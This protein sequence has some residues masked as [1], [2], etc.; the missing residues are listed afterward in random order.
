VVE[1][2]EV[3]Q[4]EVEQVEVEQVEVEQV[5][6]EQVEVEQVEVEV[7]GTSEQLQVRITWAGGSQTEGVWVRPSARYSDRSDYARLCARVQDLTHAGWS[8]EAMAHQLEIDG[9][10]TLR[11][12]S[13][14]SWRVA[15]VQTLRH[16]LG[17]GNTHRQGASREAL[18]PNAWW[19]RELA[20]RL[21]IS[22][23]SLLYWIEHGLVR[24]RKERGGWQRW[25]V[26]ADAQEM[27]RLQGYRD[28]DI[29]AEHRR[30]W[31]AG[32]SISTH[33]KGSTA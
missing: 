13:E 24:A 31:T 33:Q 10:P 9:F 3:E 11:R 30:R 19:A 26:W 14:Q 4:V 5:E 27:E 8:L 25:I 1:Q 29:G 18:G 32:L 17:L 21:G 22:R 28:R 16:Q 2:V 7:Q 15:S 23:N 6:V 12:R 20:D